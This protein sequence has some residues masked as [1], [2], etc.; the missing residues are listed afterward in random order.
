MI[1]ID[2]GDENIK[3]IDWMS[4]VTNG[5]LKFQKEESGFANTVETL[6]KSSQIKGN[7]STA[8]REFAPYSEYI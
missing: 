4:T 2:F 5:Y 6:K 1:T 7:L 8:E 3:T